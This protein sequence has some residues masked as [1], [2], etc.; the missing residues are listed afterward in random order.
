MTLREIQHR[1]LSANSLAVFT[2]ICLGLCFATVHTAY[3]KTIMVFAPHPDDESLMAAGVINKAVLGGDRVIV[4]VVT[5]GDAGGSTP[6]V[7]LGYQ[8]EGETV[9][10]MSL[11][12][13]AEPNIIFM[14]Y[15]NG[16]MLN[17]Y[18]STSDT[19]I[20]TSP[21]GQTKTYGNR[22]LGN[23]DFHSY[24]YGAAGDYN[25]ATI[26]QDMQDLLLIARPDDIYTTSQYDD[27]PDHKATYLFVV[28]ALQELQTQGS[29]FRTRLHESLVHAPCE[30]CDPNYLWPAPVFTPTQLFPKPEFLNQTP[31]DWNVIESLPV[32]VSM[33]SLDPST[34]LKYQAI[35][36][37]QSQL[38][39]YG[40]SFYFSFVK[41]NEFFWVTNYSVYP[42]IAPLAS[43]VDFSSQNVSTGQLA[44]KAID[45]I[46]DGSPKDYTKEWAT[47][48]GKAGSYIQLNWSQS[49]LI[50]QVSLYD[51]P[52]PND[53][54]L[55]G[56]LSFSDGSSLDVGGVPNG[57][58]PF[59]V[60]FPQKSVT[61]VRFT[62]N[63]VSPTTVNIGLAEIKVFGF[64]GTAIP[65]DFSLTTSGNP[66][67]TAG[68]SVFKTI[69]LN[70][71]SGT[72]QT[73]TLSTSGLPSGA[74]A[75]FSRSSCSP[76]CSTTLTLATSSS[77]V[78]GS[79]PITVTGTAGSLSRTTS[80]NLIVTSSSTPFYGTPF[81]IPATIQAEDFDNGGEGVAYHDTDAANLGGQYRS[82]GVDIEATTDT[83]GGFNVGWVKG[84]EWLK[85]S[86]SVPSAGSYNLDTRVASAGNG[87]TFHIEI[88][89]VDNTGPMTVPNTGGWQ[90]WQ[91][92]T[93]PNVSLSAGT[94]VMRLVMDSNGGT[95]GVGN[96][97]WISIH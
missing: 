86:I 65:F 14:G 73:V 88:D 49:Y 94:H 72:T 5:N 93:K 21:A 62:V 19:T 23:S 33:Q 64:A 6:G 60:V 26:L 29:G 1:R 9:A 68:T 34:N 13:L 78:A 30:R 27:H 56:T 50:D 83:G 41:L 8:R 67:V 91:T 74:T 66:T 77:T 69:A 42:N 35:S 44:T 43:S 63:S 17:I 37:Y 3:S 70:L 53:Q 12:G 36:Q 4:V 97:N 55:S 22:G 82:T 59:D 11:L 96:F 57:A 28:S 90:I 39:F 61:W 76:S 2:V 48:G 51:R 85:Y 47:V 15:P 92:L 80:F 87:G 95:G 89:G 81:V 32:P 45:G 54:I 24:W 7:N 38:T 25:R 58:T 16:P 79:Y 31:L 75:S 71:V 40:S 20:F 46:V 52:N 18:N 10:A 84:G